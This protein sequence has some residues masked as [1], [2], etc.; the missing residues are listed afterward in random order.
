MSEETLPDPEDE[1]VLQAQKDYIKSIAADCPMFGT[2]PR[3]AHLFAYIDEARKDPELADQEYI[4]MNGFPASAV[5]LGW[6]KDACIRMV[7]EKWGEYGGYGLSR[8]IDAF[9][10]V[11]IQRLKTASVRPDAE[12][13][14]IEVRFETKDDHGYYEYRFAVPMPDEPDPSEAAPPEGEPS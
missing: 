12:R 1:A 13:G 8:L 3:Q 5:N 2:D 4:P 6:L 9:L 10:S 11:C 14:T 7:A